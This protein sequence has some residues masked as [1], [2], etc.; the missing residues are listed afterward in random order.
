MK[1]TK[2]LLFILLVC[3]VVM[4]VSLNAGAQSKKEAAKKDVKPEEIFKITTEVKCTPVKSQ[5]RAGI[6]WSFSTVSFLESELLRMGKEEF[7]LSEIYPVRWLY[8]LKAKNFIRNHGGAPHSP[9]GQA[10]H[11]IDCLRAAG[12]VPDDV[13]S[14]LNLG[15][16]KHNHSEL[17][18]V[19]QGMLDGVLKSNRPTL[20]WLEAYEAVLDIYLGKVPET[21]SYKGTT[22]TP[23][24]FSDEVLGLNPDDYIE[25]TSYMYLPYYKQVCLDIP[26]NFEHNSKYYNVPLEDFE[27]LV[28]YAITN[29]DSMGWDGDFSEKELDTRTKGYAII[30]EKAF[31][32]KTPIEQAVDFKYYDKEKEITPEVRQKLFDNYTTTDDHLMHLVGIASTQEG[33]KFY[34]IKNSHG[35]DRAYGGYLYLSRAFFLGKTTAILVHKNGIPQDLK[36]K[37][38]IK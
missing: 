15:E 10:H 6:C 5:D 35:T 31:E 18:N 17:G 12:I 4:F 37:L 3:C 24:K 14:G 30:P 9:G 34:R 29:G 19:L 38:G 11:V 27:R 23:K 28:D 26:D 20:R 13:Y 8:P 1:F 2:S 36:E 22:Y 7:D 21:F 16:K 33:K 25:V 32:D